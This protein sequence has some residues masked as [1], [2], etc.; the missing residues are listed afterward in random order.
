MERAAKK[1][2]KTNGY[3]LPD[4]LPPG[5]IL[6]DIAKK[7]WKLGPSIGKGGF[8]EIY[9]AQ[10][11]STTSK[12]KYPNVIKIEPHTNG[13]LFVEMHFYMRNAKPEFVEAFKKEKNLKY[14]G[15]PTYLGS[16]RHEHNNQIYR[17]VV[18]EKFGTDIWKLFVEN[19]HKFSPETVFKLGTQILNVL[20]YIHSRG[21]IHADIKGANVLLGLNSAA[22]TQVYLVDFGL[23]T[24]YSSTDKPNP[25]KAHNGTLQYVSR[26]G[27]LGVESRRGDLEIL[28]YNLVQW[29]GCNLPWDNNTFKTPIAVQECKEKY[30]KNLPDFFKTCFGSAK[31]PNEIVDY[32]KYVVSLKFE[33]DPDYTKLRNI[34][35]AGV[36][37]AGGSIESPFNFKSIKSP[38]KR[39][40]PPKELSAPKKIE[41][42]KKKKVASK[43]KSVNGTTKKTKKKNEDEYNGDDADR[44]DK[45]DSTVGFNEAMLAVR[46]KMKLNK[47]SAKQKTVST[48]KQLRT[49]K[50]VN[51]NERSRSNMRSDRNSFSDNEPISPRR[52]HP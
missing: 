7:K 49:R 23:C 2:K 19:N 22:M 12:N 41:E 28:G 8:G 30:M 3:K 45:D 15:M 26:D 25:K 6:E 11:F 31:P 27:H 39:K 38:N 48:K 37:A 4:P 13:P 33:V 50:N 5:L 44:V 43:A 14:L 10:E 51:Y 1:P 47:E 36:E 52:R 18:M 35:V 34:L 21:Y 9:S 29:L 20:E 46:N 16:G 42:P 17:F 40:L 32:M 24:H